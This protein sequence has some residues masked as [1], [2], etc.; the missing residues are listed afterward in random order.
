MAQTFMEV[1]NAFARKPQGVSWRPPAAAQTPRARAGSPPPWSRGVI[2]D[3][4]VRPAF[5]ADGCHRAVARVK[6]GRGGQIQKLREDARHELVVIAPQ[7][8]PSDRSGEQDVSAEDE[9]RVDVQA[10][11]DHG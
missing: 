6:R 11:I 2:L 5:P 10:V 3:E 4:W 8:G 9:R 7:V 1:R